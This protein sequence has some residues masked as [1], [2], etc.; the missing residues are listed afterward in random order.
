MRILYS[1]YP[2]QDILLLYVLCVLPIY[3]DMSLFLFV[4]ISLISSKVEY[5]FKCLFVFVF[6]LLWIAIFFYW[7]SFLF[8]RFLYQFGVLISLFVFHIYCNIYSH[9]YF[10]LCIFCQIEILNSNV[11]KYISLLSQVVVFNVSLGNF[12][13]LRYKILLFVCLFLPFL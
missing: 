6:F 1:C 10:A 9:S 12:S 2:Q 11:T 3:N 5:L 7:I 8:I 4:C 13:Q